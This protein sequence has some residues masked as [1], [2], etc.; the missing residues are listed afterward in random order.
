M[1]QTLPYSS[2]P[3]PDERRIAIAVQ[4]APTPT[5]PGTL[6]QHGGGIDI[7]LYNQPSAARHATY[8]RGASI[9]GE[10][11]LSTTHGATSVQ[12]TVRLHRFSV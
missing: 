11:T 10:I 3:A 4:D 9:A 12:I 5:S 8:G 2:K 7:A 6:I 1:L